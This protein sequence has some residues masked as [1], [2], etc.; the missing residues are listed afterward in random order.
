MTKYA[1][2][3]GKVNALGGDN[4]FKAT[5]TCDGVVESYSFTH[6]K[7]NDAPSGSIYVYDSVNLQWQ[8]IDWNQGVVANDSDSI[9][10]NLM[11]YL[12]G[13]TNGTIYKLTITA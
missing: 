3:I 11:N 6:G 10:V 7:N 5:I 2:K 13:N 4:P 8:P 12:T 9:T 1:K